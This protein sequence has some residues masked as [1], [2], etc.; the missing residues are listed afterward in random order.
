MTQPLQVLYGGA[1]RFNAEAPRKLALLALETL[2][3][4]APDAARFAEMTGVDPASA[5]LVRAAVARRLSQP[6]GFDDLRVDFEDG[7]GPR[8]DTEE[9]AH[10]LAVGVSL[11][12]VPDPAPRLGVRVK[13]MGP[14]TRSRALRTLRA[15]IR[16]CV[17]ARGGL[18][19][20]FVVTLPKISRADEVSALCAALQAEERGLSLPEG[21]IGVELMVET[22]WSLSNVSSLVETAGAR[23]ESLHLGAYDLLSALQIRAEVQSLQHPIVALA[24]RQLALMGAAA[25][26]RVSDGATTL[27]PV[28][29]HRGALSE[30]QRSENREAVAAGWR[31]HIGDIWAGFDDGI[32]QGWDLHPNQLVSRY[33]GVFSVQLAG[34]DGVL[35]RLGRFVQTAA[36]AVRAGAVFD[37]AATAQ[38]LVAQTLAALDSGLLD[39]DTVAS[40]VGVSVELLRG[41][42][43]AAMVGV[44][45]RAPSV[46]P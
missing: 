2:D 25:S 19:Q 18:P 24:R 39:E 40:R 9:D 13:S 44:R 42:S 46:R 7:Y 8:S 4:Y 16:A 11:A 26:I 1:H 35:D 41:R 20:G 28:G 45:P 38:G 22:P 6:A 36:Q 14:E 10:A 21:L 43:F 37:D 15:V 23:L 27:L 30:A 3:Q 33:A 5:D 29:P 31:R 17:E 12:A 32:R 34:L